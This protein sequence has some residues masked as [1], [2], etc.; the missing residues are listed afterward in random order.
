MAFLTAKFNFLVYKSVVF[1]SGFATI[2][3]VTNQL[4]FHFMYTDSVITMLKVQYF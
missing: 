2:Y 4:H 1:S 3:E